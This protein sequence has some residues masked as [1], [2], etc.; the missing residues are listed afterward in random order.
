MAKVFV[1]VLGNDDR[2]TQD[3]ETVGELKTQLNLSSY[4]ATVNGS[5]ADNSQEL[6]DD[7]LVM[8]APAVK[9]GQ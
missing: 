8:F 7:Q 3:A 5:P 2:S 9:G 1:K 6:Q 4:S